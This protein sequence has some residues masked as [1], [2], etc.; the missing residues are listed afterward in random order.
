MHHSVSQ[1]CHVAFI[2]QTKWPESTLEIQSCY[3]SRL[4]VLYVSLTVHAHVLHI[5]MLEKKLV[6]GSKTVNQH[7]WEV[8]KCTLQK[9][10]RELE[11]HSSPALEQNRNGSFHENWQS[12][13]IMQTTPQAHDIL[14][15]CQTWSLQ[16][17][18][19]LDVAY[20]MRYKLHMINFRLLMPRSSNLSSRSSV[21][22]HHHLPLQA[23]G[24]TEAAN[25]VTWFT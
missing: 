12:H 3:E 21:I 9:V 16:R 23:N 15:I 17:S 2:R 7:S 11:H 5:L 10:E 1:R 25:K 8:V 20:E 19:S 6:C 24:K 22:F 18:I 14:V 4:C 13:L